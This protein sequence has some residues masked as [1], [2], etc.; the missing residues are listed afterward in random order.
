MQQ[1]SFRRVG[2]IPGR[3]QQ[4]LDGAEGDSDVEEEDETKPRHTRNALFTL[5]LLF[6]GIIGFALIVA[7]TEDSPTGISALRGPIDRIITDLVEIERPEAFRKQHAAEQVPEDHTKEMMDNAIATSSSAVIIVPVVTT[8]T[9]SVSETT[10]STANLQGC[11]NEVPPD[12]GPHI[13]PPPAGPVTLVC[14]QSTKGPLTIAVH[15]TWAPLGAQRFLDMVTSGFFSSKIGLFRALKGFIIQF[16]LS[17]DPS[18][19]QV[20]CVILY[21]ATRCISPS[22][23]TELA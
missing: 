12:S 21:I 23:R 16:G 13:V 6:I 15:K 18:V 2:G 14:C 22:C 4:D 1:R 7:P 5:T 20:S 17:G 3:G 9:T 11:V 10:T 8:S 19:Q